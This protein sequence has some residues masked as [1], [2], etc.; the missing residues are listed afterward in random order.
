MIRNFAGAAPGGASE[1]DIDDAITAHDAA[2]DPHGDRS[3]ADTQ[4]AT[5]PSLASTAPTTSAAGDAAAAGAGTT[6]AKADHTHGRE[7]FGSVTA[8]TS[9]GV[10]SGNGSAAT[11]ARSDHNHGTPSLTS[12]AATTSAVGDAAAVGV[13]TAPARA[14]HTH[15]RE[16]FGASAPTVASVA[17]GV[18]AA[19]TLARS[20]HYHPTNVLAPPDHGL[21]GWNFPPYLAVS[22]ALAPATGTVYV[23]KVPVPPGQTITNVIIGIN[24]VGTNLTSGQNFAGLLSSSKAL[25]AATADQTSNWGTN[26]GPIIMALASTQSSGSAGY[27]YVAVVTVFGGGGTGPTLYRAGG[28]INN[29]GLTN[30]TAVFATGGTGQTSIPSNVTTTLYT[31]AS[32]WAAVS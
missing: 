28:N 2:T 25:L 26:T 30:A 32:I 19:T 20:D 5:K 14:D 27:V 23:M 9:Y 1:Q 11:L 8:A 18:G 12:S 4:V 16:A 22:S 7:A 3:Y 29:V 6:A 13:A 31:S 15:G 17:G 24:A 21:L 10:S